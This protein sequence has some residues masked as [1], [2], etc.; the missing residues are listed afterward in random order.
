MGKKE[1]VIYFTLFY[2]LKYAS[3]CCNLIKLVNIL[4]KYAPKEQKRF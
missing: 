2:F 3:L 1:S 4:R